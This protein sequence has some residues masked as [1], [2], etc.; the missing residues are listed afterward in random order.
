[1]RLGVRFAAP[2]PDS[3]SQPTSPPIS[4][5]GRLPGRLFGEEIA[6]QIPVWLWIIG[7][8]ISHTVIAGLALMYGKAHPTVQAK[9]AADIEAAAKKIGL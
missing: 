3:A 7:A 9:V 6:M 2:P 5:S 4:F 8:V 1:M